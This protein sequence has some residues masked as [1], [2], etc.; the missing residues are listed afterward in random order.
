MKKFRAKHWKAFGKLKNGTAIKLRK[1][2][3]SV[4]FYFKLGKEEHVLWSFTEA[5][6]GGGMMDWNEYKERTE[7]M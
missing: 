7:K 5:E 3:D 4:E 6:P 2:G 1:K